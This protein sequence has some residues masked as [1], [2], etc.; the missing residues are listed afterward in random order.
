MRL[1]NVDYL[2]GL[3]AFGIMIYHY[4]SWTFGIFE[5]NTFMGRVGVYGVSVFYVLSG[6]TLYYVYHKNF[7]FKKLTSF[8]VKRFFRI[9]PL[10]WL[11]IVLTI[12]L[13]NKT[14]ENKI[15]IL[16]ITG[17]FGFF[18]HDKYITSG[19]WSIGNEL[20]FYS[21]F[22][23]ILLFEKCFKFTIE[24]FFTLSFFVSMYFGFFVFN[25]LQTLGDQ[26]K[27]YINPLNQL[28]F[29]SGGLLI[30]KLLINKNNTKVGVTLLL[31]SVLLFV[32]Y[33]TTGDLIIVVSSWN[34]IIF[35]L[36]VFVLCSSIIVIQFKVPKLF[37]VL[38]ETLG[39]ISYSLYLL[40][41]IVFWYLTNYINRAEHFVMFFSCS[42][43]ITFI[44]SLA[45]YYLIEKPFILLGKRL[46][47]SKK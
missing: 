25:P 47:V 2:R 26:W 18:E 10:L 37:D 24:V 34:K 12:Y 20:V 29:F 6:L 22:P 9:Y 39:K 31:S 32:F 46:S 30:G 33:P 11:S 5:S 28:L 16:N 7:N 4:L 13:L 43:C 15:I 8:F 35:S 40:H 41:A 3:S 19:A 44:I 1:K 45:S 27:D 42:I 21:L 14:F 38:L 36:L 17:L 23:F